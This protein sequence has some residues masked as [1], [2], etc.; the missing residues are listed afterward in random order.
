MIE[1]LW[2]RRKTVRL[3]GTTGSGQIF[4][5]LLRVHRLPGKSCPVVGVLSAFGNHRAEVLPVASSV[6]GFES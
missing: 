5:E 1:F 4:R 3:G 2:V 6:R